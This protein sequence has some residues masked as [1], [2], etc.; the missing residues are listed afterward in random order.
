MRILF[1]EQTVLGLGTT[2]GFVAPTL[3]NS[4]LLL[5]LRMLPAVPLMA[6]LATWLYPP[7]WHEIRKLSKRSQR[8]ALGHAL[9]GGGLMFAYLGLLYVSIGLIATAIALTLFF[10]FP[11][12]TALLSWRFLKQKPTA[13]QWG[14]MTCILL[15]SILTI[16]P[17]QWT[18]D[19]GYWGAVLGIAS[20]MA[21]ATYTINAQKSF[22]YMH[23]LTYTWASFALT[24]WFAALCLIIWPI[25]NLS[26]L[27]WTPLWIG[28]IISGIVT[29][30]GHI[31]YNLG[32]RSIGAT[33][34]AMIGSTNPALTVV[35][36]W[37]AIQE[38]LG[39]LQLLGVSIVTAS[40][41]SLSRSR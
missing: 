27:R 10:T 36:A 23:P 1:A 30:I 18:G 33:A 19:G 41:A 12:F 32:I 7:I 14:I 22:N 21:Y 15:G 9:A 24:L 16:P 37:V 4:F 34:A 26:E 35:L 3:H 25:D 39:S 40:V 31:L 2:G 20:G 6:L 17:Q 8:Q 28:S 38:A 11:I 13:L 29:F 5:L